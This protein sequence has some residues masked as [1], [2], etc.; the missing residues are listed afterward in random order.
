MLPPL[1]NLPIYSKDIWDYLS[2]MPYMP[3]RK[4]RDDLVKDAEAD[5]SKMKRIQ[6]WDYFFRIRPDD[7]AKPQKQELI[8]LDRKVVKAQE[9][10]S[11]QVKKLEQERI[12][13]TSERE[14]LEIEAQQYVNDQVK[15]LEQER[16]K[17]TSEQEKLE[18]EV[19]QYTRDQIKKLEQEQA[20]LT[21]ERE[22]LEIEA[23]QY[24]SD[25]IKKL[26]QEQAQLTSELELVQAEFEQQKK[27]G[28]K[29]RVIEQLTKSSKRKRTF[30]ITAAFISAPSLLCGL[31]MLGVATS[32]DDG[33]I[34]ILLSLGG[35]SIG[36]PLAIL[37]MWLFISSS[38]PSSEK[39]KQETAVLLEKMRKGTYDP[40]IE[41]LSQNIQQI[42]SR[43]EAIRSGQGTDSSK[44]AARI[45]QISQKIQQI[46]ARIEAVQSGQ[47]TDSSK[48]ATRISQISQNIQQIP[49]RI[50]AVQS[51]RDDNLAKYT[52]RITEVSQKIQ[53]IPTQIQVIRAEFETDYLQYEQRIQFLKTEISNLLAQIPSLVSDEEVETWLK[54]DVDNLTEVATDRSGLRDRLIPVLDATN[55]FCIRGPAELQHNELIP[56]PYRE[57][58]SDRH[59]HLQ[60]RS[61][62][63]M[64]DGSFADFYGV[65]N[66]EFILVTNDVL[67]T[68]GTFYDFITGRQ[69]GERT[70]VQH[71]ADVVAIR[72]MKGFREVEVDGDKKIPMENVPSLSLSLMDGD[73]IDVTFPDREYFNQ[74]NADGFSPDRWRFDPHKAADNAIKAVRQKVDIAKRKR[75]IGTDG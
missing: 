34:Y 9:Y 68:Y 52:S 1:E 69:S 40:Q 19:R 29:N 10:L 38:K 60:A 22:K 2:D 74:I 46:P 30:G 63:V 72:S 75:E 15:K 28:A 50:E 27:S 23:Q 49:S 56:I 55:P 7:V 8:E 35:C 26:E 36:L 6:L 11:N 64:P 54:E 32:A 21:S 71:Y 61:F 16:I 33:A 42:P 73:K 53:Q 18:I 41:R 39:I 58:K 43:I 51:G 45:S 17:L 37:S 3:S 65:Y 47:N 57:R 25:Q 5:P 67:A 13:L 12:K 59:K 62:V 14:K 31:L 4:D 44:Y 70:T 48:H 20:K 66:I 24:V